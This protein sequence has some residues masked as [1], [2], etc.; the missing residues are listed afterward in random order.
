MKTIGKF[1]LLMVVVSTNFGCTPIPS[2][3]PGIE[4]VA[5]VISN[6]DGEVPDNRDTSAMP[7]RRKR[8]REI[9]KGMQ[10]SPSAQELSA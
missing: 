3:V 9:C 4:T 8:H 10:L 2:G 1:L 5:G 7:C 6:E